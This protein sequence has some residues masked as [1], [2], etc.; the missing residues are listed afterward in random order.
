M[1]FKK[2]KVIK[3]QGVILGLLYLDADLFRIIPYKLMNDDV[4]VVGCT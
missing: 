3:Y 1:T 2:E 4:I